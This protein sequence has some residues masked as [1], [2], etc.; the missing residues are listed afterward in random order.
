MSMA[1]EWQDG[2]RG[3]QSESEPEPETMTRVTT[4]SK[5]TQQSRRLQ[6]HRNI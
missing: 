1:M 6:S 2:N 5:G 4:A 3:V